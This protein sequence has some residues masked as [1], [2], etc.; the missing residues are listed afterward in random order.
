L[1]ANIND[2]SREAGQGLEECYDAYAELQMGKF[3]EAHG[4]EFNMDLMTKS[5]ALRFSNALRYAS[6]NRPI[7]L[8]E[9]WYI[10]SLPDNARV[11]NTVFCAD[12]WAIT[13]HC[14]AEG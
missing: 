10:A 8:T 11:R 13:I 14:W 3:A 2:Q 12:W 5:K 4:Q 6:L 1:I 9:K 7:G